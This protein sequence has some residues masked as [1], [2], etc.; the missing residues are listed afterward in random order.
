MPHAPERRRLPVVLLEAD[1]VLPRIDA[2]RLEAVE[3]QLLHFVG[4]RLEDHLVLVMLEQPVRVLSEAAVVGPARRLDVGHAPRLRPEHAEQR[5]GMRG[6]GADFEIER[7]LQ[8]AAVRRPERRQLENEVL[9][10]HAAVRSR[11]TPKVAKHAIRFQRLLQM[12]RDQRPMHAL[13]FP[14]HPRVHRHRR[15]LRAAPPCAT[16]PET[17]APR[18][19]A[20]R[21]TSG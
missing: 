4:R 13:Q 2:A 20:C 15:H 18:P 1:V 12:H 3:I 10:R 16:P 19:T 11:V 8:Q 6:A 9:K 17:P 21:A 5:L 14:Q 7:L